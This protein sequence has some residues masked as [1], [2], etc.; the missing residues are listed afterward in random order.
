MS[1]APDVT[2]R[3]ERVLVLTPTGRDAETVEAV[4]KEA[5]MGTARCRDVGALRQAMVEDA[6]AALVAEEALSPSDAGSLRA[7]LEG[8]EPWSDLPIVL[9]VARREEQ[10]TRHRVFEL[11]APAGNVLVLERPVLKLVLVAAMAE[12]LRSRRRQYQMRDLLVKLHDQAEALRQGQAEL[13]REAA[14]RE[15]FLGVVAHDLRNPLTA[16]VSTSGVLLSRGGLTE[17]Q[18]PSVQRV[19]RA[20]QRLARMTE[21]LLDFARIRQAGGLPIAP[22]PGD[23]EEVCRHAIEELEAGRPGRTITLSRSGDPCGTWDVHRLSQ[24]VSNLVGNALDHGPRDA[25][26]RVDLEGREG[27][28]TIAV[29]NPGPPIPAEVIATIFDPWKR[30]PS[31]EQGG[32]AS[33]GLGLGLF[34]AEQIVRAH[35]GEIRASSTPEAGTTF[36]ITLPRVPATR[37]PSEPERAPPEPR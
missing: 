19:A 34:I 10:A 14:F 28:I 5:G 20:A 21:D 1:T 15:R 16:I 27:E 8:Q 7:A 30:G 25:P 6:G 26:V 9:L 36:A 11:V 23:L 37:A 12:T 4:L 33:R 22:R 35:G 32:P 29:N 24:V 17:A 31:A 2:L 18:A 3:E 13:H